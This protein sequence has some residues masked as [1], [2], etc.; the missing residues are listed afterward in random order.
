MTQMRPMLVAW[1]ALALL[2]LLYYVVLRQRVLRL[3][4]TKGEVAV[5]VIL[6]IATVGALMV[7]LGVRIVTLIAHRPAP[8][9]L[10]A[11]WGGLFS[12]TLLMLMVV[13]SQ[14]T[15]YTPE[16]SG[17]RPIAELRSIEVNGRTEWLSIRGQDRTKPVV[18]FLAGG[19][20]G[21]HLATARYYFK[22]LESEYVVVTW[23]QPGA[24]KSLGAID[25]TNITLNTYLDDGAAVAEYLCEE[26]R[27]PKIHIMG[28]SWGSALGL[29]MAHQHPEFYY[30]FI[31]TG[32]MVDFLE[33]ELIDYQKAL[34]DARKI[35][36]EALVDKLE[37]QG[38]PPHTSGV[39]LK[40]F[41]YL[42]HL[43]G[44]TAR[45]GRLNSA[46]VS[47]MDGP[48]GVEYGLLDKVNFFWGF[49]RTWD[50]FYEKLYSVDLR[51]RCPEIAVP[52]HVFHGRYDFN[53]PARLVEDYMRHLQAPE[54]SLVY[55]ERSGH[56]PWQTENDLFLQHARTV[57]QDSERGG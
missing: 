39:A 20:G 22:A 44:V 19:P 10:T 36:D 33:T 52:V 3:E 47:T 34:D 12:G 53:A 29:M 31:G 17:V 13:L 45:T 6:L 11:L 2:V 55:F 26:F 27:Q 51:E 9:A 49:F 50:V 32:Q 30:S 57:F 5:A 41:A 14:V 42:S 54:K 46:P 18:L 23:E 37:R 38:P 21:S 35:G 40:T 1:S 8:F 28:E 25:P 4:D 24:A 16:I 48:Y 56:T 7:S 43:N 15:A